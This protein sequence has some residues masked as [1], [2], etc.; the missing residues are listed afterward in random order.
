MPDVRR[1]ERPIFVKILRTV[2]WIAAWPFLFVGGTLFAYLRPVVT[3]LFSERLRFSIA[4]G[5]LFE[6]STPFRP[7]VLTHWNAPFTGG[8]RCTLPSGVQLRAA[9]VAAKGSRGCRF[10]PQDPPAFFARF[11]PQEERTDQK[12]AGISL[13]LSSREIRRHLRRA[14]AA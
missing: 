6:V 11:V 9:T 14:Q 5:D 10:V 4:E 1:L 13:P 7:F 3:W 8:F 2:F 12:F